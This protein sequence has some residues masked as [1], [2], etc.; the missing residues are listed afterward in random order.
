[1]GEVLTPGTHTLSVTFTPTDSNFPVAESSVSLVV[2][3]AMPALTWPA[4]APIPCGTAL[5]TAELNATASV[6]GTFTYSPA[7][8]DVPSAG[9]RTLSV[10]FIPEESE[11]YTTA[12]AAVRLTVTKARPII[13]WSTP[14]P[15]SYGTALSDAEFN[16]AASVPG[17]FTFTPAKG[18]VLTAGTQTLEATF[19]PED[20]ANYDIAQA[21]VPLL[22]TALPQFETLTRAPIET[23]RDDISYILQA[24][25]TV[26]GQMRRIQGNSPLE[27]AG[28]MG[29]PPRR[30]A[31]DSLNRM[32]RADSNADV[33]QTSGNSDQASEPETRTYKGATYVKGTDG[34]WHLKQN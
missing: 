9:V 20:T 14:E 4:P 24:N 17:T 6:P 16:A 19:T 21:S 7:S 23:D 34:K 32:E 18:T 28:P 31:Q 30:A 3:K 10:T 12:E 25:R 5:G 2:R 15:I 8:G 33:S 27:G 13:S 29:V 22:V 1:V 26:G 11:N